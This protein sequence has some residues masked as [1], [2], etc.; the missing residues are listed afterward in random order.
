MI[1]LLI[2]IAIIAILA[3][4]LLPALQKSRESAKKTSCIGNIKQAGLACM[5]YADDYSG[6]SPSPAQ[7]I[8]GFSRRW[9]WFLI[10]YKYIPEGSWKVFNCPTQN[11]PSAY[12]ETQTYGMCIDVYGEDGMVTRRDRRITVPS[13][14]AQDGRVIPASSV[15][16]LADSKF[17]ANDNQSGL[18]TWI[19][20]AA[21]TVHVRHNKRANFFMLDGSVKDGERIGRFIDVVYPGIVDALY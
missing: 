17:L 3:A 12:D 15:W 11:P 7:N 21:Y 1:E 20:G 4:M 6:I 9:S 19:S 16:Y 10:Q 8:N 13:V 5:N 14:R 18:I 2:V